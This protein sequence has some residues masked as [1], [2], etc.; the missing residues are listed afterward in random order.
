[1]DVTTN[2]RY[3]VFL[4][5]HRSYR[6]GLWGVIKIVGRRGRP[7]SYRIPRHTTLDQVDDAS[8]VERRILLSDQLDRFLCYE[9][10]D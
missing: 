2:N 3:L 1:M 5:L 6:E 7:G 8:P 9:T 4:S 10:A